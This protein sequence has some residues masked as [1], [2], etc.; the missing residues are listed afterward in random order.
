MS[1]IVVLN[2]LVSGCGLTAFTFIFFQK[3]ESS[4]EANEEKLTE[5]QM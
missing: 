4:Y 3:Q 1:A 2:I 5:Y